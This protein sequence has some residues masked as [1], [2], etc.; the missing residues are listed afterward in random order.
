[1]LMAKID[2][3]GKAY[4]RFREIRDRRREIRAL[5][6]EDDGNLDLDAIQ[7]ELEQ[8]EQEELELEKKLRTLDG[9]QNR[10]IEGRVI[11]KPEGETIMEFE[12]MKPE[13]VRATEEYRNAFFKVMQGKEL[14]EQEKRAYRAVEQRSFTTGSTSAGP[15]IPTRTHDE[16]IKKLKQS[17][18]LFPHISATQF[19]GNVKIPVEVG[20][21]DA[22]WLEELEDI[23]ETGEGLESV[24]LTGHTLAKL[25]PV[26]IA[27][28]T[29]TV[30]AFENYLVDVIT[31]K[32]LIAIEKAILN[33]TG[34]G[35]PTGI[36]TGV[37]WTDGENSFTY[38]AET[39][40]TYD[41]MLIPLAN[42][43][44]G[45]LSNAAWC[46]SSSTLYD[47]VAKI[48]SEDGKSIFVPDA[49]EGFAGMIMG[50][51]VVIDDYMPTGTILFGNF[52][53]YFM[54]FSQPIVFEK[55]RESGF[56]KASVDYRGVAVLDGKPVLDEAF[57]KLSEGDAA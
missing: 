2:P 3:N 33:G 4:A 30:Q 56:R 47:R 36:L 37:T 32:L 12:N 24:T 27:A 11:P 55:S 29:M 41:D 28:E 44:S 15:A 31:E 6:K 54:N 53:Y 5:L 49:I 18:A 10:M 35:Q 40:L 50:K 8:L 22:T 48:T 1:M 17:Q 57:I 39:G 14:T 16:V 21:S 45:Y 51:P 38:A 20:E 23:P 46:M 9:L 19:S 43:G 25:V 42:L 26:S 34:T 52:R 7:K 13:E